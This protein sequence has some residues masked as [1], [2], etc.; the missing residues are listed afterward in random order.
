MP[1]IHTIY[2]NGTAYQMPQGPRGPQGDSAVFDPQTGNVLATLH[3]TTGYDDAN[4]MTQKAVTVELDKFTTEQLSGFTWYN[5]AINSS[6]YLLDNKS[7][8]CTDEF[9]F[10]TSKID[11]VRIALP[12][13]H[14]KF[15]V[16]AINE[17]GTTITYS[18]L[19]G[20]YPGNES[21][22]LV[23][24][25][26]QV[27][28]PVAGTRYVI[29]QSPYPTASQAARDALTSSDIAFVTQYYKSAT[30]AIDDHA[31]RIARIEEA[32]GAVTSVPKYRWGKISSS[33]YSSNGNTES[34][35]ISEEHLFDPD[36]V[37][38]VEVRLPANAGLKYAVYAIT[39]STYEV[40]TNSFV[41]RDFSFT[42]VGGSKYVVRISPNTSSVTRADMEAVAPSLYP[43]FIVRYATARRID[44][45]EN[46]VGSIG[47]KA[48]GY[49]RNYHPVTPLLTFEHKMISAQG[50]EDC[51][52]ALLARMPNIGCVEVKM[53]KPVGGFSVW[54]RYGSTISCLQPYTHYQFR[55]TGDHESEYFVMLQKETGEILSTA[56][57]SVYTYSDEGKAYNYVA[58]TWAAGKRIAFLG[59][60]I[61]QGRYPKN[62]AE[63]VNLCMDKPWPNLVAETLGAEDFTDFAI[64]GALVYNS[65]W[66]SLQ[67]NAGL[68]TGYD[69]VFVCGGTNDY[70]GKVS[71]ALFEAAYADMLDTLI[72]NNTMVI[73]MTPVY[74][75]KTVSNPVM[76][77]SGYAD[78]ITEKATEKGVTV[79]PMLSLTNN[80][81]FKAHLVDGIHPDETGHRMIADIVLDT[82]RTI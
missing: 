37:T 26:E 57:A 22:F 36:E 82:I 71:K 31:T 56:I 27:F 64:G 81:D 1:T 42:P 67:R 11:K 76:G 74:R 55:Y 79:V 80:A 32:I 18:N 50:I 3:N 41:T 4:A 54:K 53:N 44:N 33:G 40:L 28:T 39:G 20:E 51:P 43:Y 8:K 59:D 65:D 10:D 47:E 60:S 62:S 61:V 46:R 52:T 29:R 2:R 16:Y 73:A 6:G 38:A 49:H 7:N 68:I 78:S 45:L 58:P 77:L 75:T 14:T 9:T 13:N 21:G 12:N 24:P 70:G 19:T 5:K 35:K 25:S 17:S 23:Y 15:A 69:I 34:N 66:K 48:Y 63:G 30:H 72:A